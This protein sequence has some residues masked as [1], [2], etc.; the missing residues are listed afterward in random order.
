MTTTAVPAA[1]QAEDRLWGAKSVM[2]YLKDTFGW[3]VGRQWLNRLSRRDD[4]PLPMAL[5][6]EGRIARVCA[7][8]RKLNAW[9]KRNLPTIS[10]D[11][12]L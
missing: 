12:S 7:S 2:R 5:K 4:D 6:T 1:T 3:S 11:C 8:K 10:S 9:A